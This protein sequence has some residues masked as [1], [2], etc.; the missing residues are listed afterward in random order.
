MEQIVPGSLPWVS[1][2]HAVVVVRISVNRECGTSS[3]GL[4]LLNNRGK[5]GVYV[6][7]PKP[8]LIGSAASVLA[9]SYSLLRMSAAP[10]IYD[11]QLGGCVVI[12]H[13]TIYLR[14]LPKAHSSPLVQTLSLIYAKPMWVRASQGDT[15]GDENQDEEEILRQAID[16]SPGFVDPPVC[17]SRPESNLQDY[18]YSHL[19]S[20]DKTIRLLCIPP[21]DHISDPLVCGMR[22]VRLNDKPVY[23]ALSYT[24]GAP[25]FD[26]HIICDGRRLA[27]TAHL[28]AAL[29]RFRTTTW[30][31]LWVDALCIDQTNIPERNYQVSIMKHIYSQ[32]SLTFVYLGESCPLDVEVL[33]LMQVLIYWA[34]ILHK[35]SLAEIENMEPS[36]VA[37][38]RARD[39]AIRLIELKKAP[40]FFKREWTTILTFAGFPPPQHPVWEAMQ[41]LFSHPW[42][43]RMWIIQEV[44]LSS[45]VVVMRGEH[46]ISWRMVTESMHAYSENG[47]NLWH[48]TKAQKKPAMR[49]FTESS[50][51]VLGLLKVR[52]HQCRSL[53]EL[54][55][56]F[57]NCRC[58]D[59]RDKVYA[60]LGLANDQGA[61]EMVSVDY[62]KSVEAVYLE[63]ANILV[64]NGHGVEMLIHAGILQGCNDTS[65]D[66]SSDMS[67]PSWV[68]D[69]SRAMITTINMWGEL[70]RAAGETLPDMDFETHGVGLRVKGIRIDVID[71][72][73][74]V[75]D[76]YE[77]GTGLTSRNTDAAWEQGLREVA[78]QSRFFSEERLDDYVKALGLGSCHRVG[79]NDG[80]T[81]AADFDNFWKEEI[82]TAVSANYYSRA[83]ITS[84]HHKFCVTRLGYM[85]WAPAYSQ[86]GDLIIVLYGGPM[87]F[88][89]RE[90]NG[91]YLLVGPTYLLGFM[92]GEALNL[93]GVE[94]EH[95]V[96]V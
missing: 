21:T 82:S 36:D 19:P 27:I 5:A 59:P 14:T 39:G 61:P 60:L 8:A 24:W 11:V 12:C 87:P 86:P 16:L 78:R 17:E 33:K 38:S 77:H 28:D 32:A 25:V 20:T 64:G 57:R 52:N 70:Y 47:L 43:T 90:T 6:Q 91:G 84:L 29:R 13:N 72:L 22:Q 89:I 92:N 55:N 56:S 51:S 37:T 48:V 71:A 18:Q 46:R 69:W 68:P 1:I 44:G 40:H 79:D 15:R 65:N 41:L 31:M 42:F 94:P 66:T 4:A 26:H 93:E 88:T 50:D 80:Y 10:K 63:C 83:N 81:T 96:L 3:T 58:S 53:I 45:N 74:P 2:K 62:S 7:I 49:N 30:W 54:L 67:L 23:A 73:A 76:V 9:F 95:F 85:G 75:R 35:Y 34:Q